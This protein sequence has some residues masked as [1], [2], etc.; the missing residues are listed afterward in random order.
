MTGARAASI[1][2][3][4]LA[5]TAVPA[6]AQTQSFGPFTIDGAA[7]QVIR[8]DGVIDTRSGLEFNRARRAAPAARILVVNSPGG[9]P[10]I[11]LQIADAVS[12]NR[13]TTVIPEEAVCF[14]SCAYVFLGGAVRQARGRLGVHQLT[15]SSSDVAAAQL[16]LSEV[17]DFLSR[18]GH[19]PEILRI[20]LAT[21]ADQMHIFSRDE[22]LRLKIETAGAEALALPVL[23]DRNAGIDTGNGPGA[24]AGADA[25]GAP[26]PVDR[27]PAVETSVAKAAIRL[28]PPQMTL[29]PGLPRFA[30][31][32]S[33]PSVLEGR[34]AGP[35]AD[36][37]S[38]AG[39]GA[40]ARQAPSSRLGIPLAGTAVGKAAI[41]LPPPVMKLP[42]EPPNF[43]AK[44][45][46][47]EEV[48][49]QRDGTQQSGS[50]A[51]LPP[52]TSLLTKPMG[53]G[54]ASAASGNPSFGLPA[55]A[56][57]LQGDGPRF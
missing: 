4:A 12:E 47:E 24:R 7:P 2:A 9:N 44:S 57:T 22:L 46:P 32:G 38:E 50:V 39:T 8:L 53:V 26:P 31:T 52:A 6:A 40:D 16:A 25:G 51:R 14:S 41:R 21:P 56:M 1:L 33:K 42:Q 17:V 29:S 49:A 34:N 48:A 19:A 3:L 18:N 35:D 30:A 27:S 43:A 54:R 28:P 23:A 37:G 36:G 45:L 13:F 10:I 15:S 20:L 11:A 5:L 55:P